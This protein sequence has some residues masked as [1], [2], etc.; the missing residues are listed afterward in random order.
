M[1]IKDVRIKY[2]NELLSGI[3]IVKFYAWEQAF[4]EKITFERSK[5]INYFK[6]TY[7]NESINWFIFS[8]SPIGV[9]LCTIS[10]YIFVIGG[11]FN[12]EKA[13]VA[14]LIF[15]ILDS[16]VEILPTIIGKTKFI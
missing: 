14:I 10:V 2:I 1:K 5:E 11:E 3:K 6:K 7:I 13:F 9:L 15:N 4:L 16:P 8:L 12:P